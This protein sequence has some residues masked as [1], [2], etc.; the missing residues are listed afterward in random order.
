MPY[1]RSASS[2]GIILKN[3]QA[4]FRKLP[5]FCL[6]LFALTFVSC[7]PLLNFGVIVAQKFFRSGQPDRQDLKAILPKGIKT[8][9]N[10]RESVEG[11]ESWLA[12]KYQVSL[13]HIPMSA[14]WPPTDAQLETYFSILDDPAHYPIWMHCEGGADRTGVMTAVYRLEYQNWSKTKAIL[15]MIRHFHIP[16][17]YPRLTR[18]IRD[19]PRKRGTY[20]ESPQ[21]LEAL[22]MILRKIEEDDAILNSIK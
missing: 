14:E 21:E 13:Y 2:F 9:I 19:Y 12:E 8:L 15:E 22:D 11:F 16:L 4:N 1:K 6:A 7:N 3:S 18:Y 10:L 17:I 20:R 5:V